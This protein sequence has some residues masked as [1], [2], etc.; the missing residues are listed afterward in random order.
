MKNLKVKIALGLLLLALSSL[1]LLAVLEPSSSVKLM[2]WLMNNMIG[3]LWIIIPSIIALLSLVILFSSKEDFI[4]LMDTTI[5]LLL[6]S[7]I[8]FLL[9][10]NLAPMGFGIAFVILFFLFSIWGSA[11][12]LVVALI[13]KLLYAAIFAKNFKEVV[14]Y[15]LKVRIVKS[16]LLSVTVTFVLFQLYLVANAIEV[17]K[18]VKVQDVAEKNNYSLFSFYRP[19]VYEIRSSGKRWSYGRVKFV[20]NGR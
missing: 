14:G 3:I 16:I 1:F 13:I 19:Y 11:L 6:I 12:S 4:R 7:N 9:F 8:T 2:Q 15:L 18:A 10:F 20:D 5:T 17:Y